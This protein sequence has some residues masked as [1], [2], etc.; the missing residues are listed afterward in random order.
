MYHSMESIINFI[1]SIPHSME[2][3]WIIPGRVKYCIHTWGGSVYVVGIGVGVNK[4][5]PVDVA[6]VECRLGTCFMSGGMSFVGCCGR[7]MWEGG[8]STW[9]MSASVGMTAGS[10]GTCSFSRHGVCTVRGGYIP[11]KEVAGRRRPRVHNR[12]AGWRA[13]V[14]VVSGGGGGGGGSG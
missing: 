3:I 4:V 5:G 11:G 7:H 6:A 13:V 2:S 10:C 8:L 14:E 9:Q 1:E 12:L